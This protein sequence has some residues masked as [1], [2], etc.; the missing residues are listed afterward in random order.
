MYALIPKLFGRTEMY[1]TKLIDVHFWITTIGVVLYI[2]SMWIAGRHAGPDVAGHE[3]GRHADLRVHRIHQGH[4]PYYACAWRAARWCSPRMLIMAYNGLEDVSGPHHDRRLAGSCS[5]P[6]EPAM[7]HERIEK[8]VGLM[9]VLI[10]IVISI[11]GLVQ[12]VPLYFQGVSTN[13]GAGGEALRAA[14]ARGP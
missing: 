7:N 6:E 4:Y 10:A 1:S 14:A 9:G 3:R 2:T 8:N 11:G 5:R 12:I 13:A